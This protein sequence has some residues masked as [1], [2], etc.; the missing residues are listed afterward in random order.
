MR[1]LSLQAANGTLSDADRSLLNQE[2]QELAQE[3]N[4]IA[5]QTEFNGIRLLDGSFAHTVV[6]AG[7][8]AG[9]K[10]SINLP[11]LTSDSVFSKV[12][13]VGAGIFQTRTTLAGSSLSIDA[14]YG[15]VNSD[16]IK[17]LVVADTTAAT[18]SIFI[19]NGD[20]TFKAR[21]TVITGTGDSRQTKLADFNNDGK[22]DLVTVSHQSPVGV[23]S[24]NLGNG[25]GTF[26]SRTTFSG[27]DSPVGL[28]VADV[29]ADGK[30]DILF[31]TYASSHFSLALGNGDGTF[32]TRVTFLAGSGPYHTAVG[33]F[34]RDG[35]V[36][37]VLSELG[38]SDMTILLGNGDGTFQAR[39]TAQSTSNTNSV[40]A[41]DLNNDGIL[42]LASTN[43]SSATLSLVL[44]NGDGSF[45]ARTTLAL[46]QGPVRVTSGDLNGDGNIDLIASSDNFGSNNL[47]S[48]Y[49]GNGDGTFKT[50]ATYGTG[51]FPYGVEV[52]D[53]NNDSVL[54]I[55]SPDY[56]AGTVSLLF[57]TAV[58][59]NFIPD[60][61][62][63]TQ[64]NASDLLEFLDNALQEL[65]KAR[66]DVTSAL[67]RLDY[68]EE[69]NLRLLESLSEAH[70]QVYDVDFALETAELV[71]NQILQQVQVALFAQANLNQ[72]LVLKLLEAS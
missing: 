22:L 54:D 64:Q 8:N 59:H 66:S 58:Q 9:Q 35:K 63:S 5:T 19:G 42:D 48:V 67:H 62:I 14:A 55:V 71:K 34:N 37:V 40:I 7:I 17:D 25:N 60:L 2:F 41:V 57:G 53:V 1:D 72:S 52:F 51:A 10:W 68:S 46:A 61:D 24:V 45:K 12:I 36:D 70:S 32:Q 15:D 65:S 29:N 3:Y 50:R 23:V 44:G 33:D 13:T 28:S 31:A 47:V 16:G 6:Q 11:S 69:S 21:S 4:R 20:G 30:Q 43:Y 49:L 27:G 56:G 38:S 26:Q 18:S 39:R